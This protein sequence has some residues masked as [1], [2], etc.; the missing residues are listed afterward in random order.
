MYQ[1]KKPPRWRTVNEFN[2]TQWPLT[3]SWCP[4]HFAKQRLVCRV[5]IAIHQRVLRGVKITTFSGVKEHFFAFN[6][7]GNF[8]FFAIVCRVQIKITA[9]SLSESIAFFCHG[10]FFPGCLFRCFFKCKIKLF[11]RQI[12][13]LLHSQTR[14][15]NPSLT[16]LILLIVL[17]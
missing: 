1:L 12:V 5:L 13:P 17:N 8:M 4:P 6:D 7:D 10:L 11:I 14:V 9:F 15:E 16:L 2:M 3:S